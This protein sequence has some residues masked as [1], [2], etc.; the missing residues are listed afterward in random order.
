M[1]DQRLRRER[2]GHRRGEPLPV[3]RQR[4]ARRQ[5]VPVAHGQDQRAQPAHLLVQQAHGIAHGIVGAERVGADQLGQPVGLVR[6]GRAHG[7]HLVQHHGHAAPCQL[8]GGFA[9]GEATADDMDGWG[10]GIGPMR[11]WDGP[12]LL[13]DAGGR[14]QGAT[15]S[16]T[17][18]G[19]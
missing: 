9:P 14:C 16:G 10:H 18:C 7:P 15:P 13:A 17:A 2:F 8:P 6:L 19:L 5:L 4:P 11:G 12:S 3:D 1:R